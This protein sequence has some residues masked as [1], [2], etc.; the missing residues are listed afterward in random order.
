MK[1]LT[2][3]KQKSY[4]PSLARIESFAKRFSKA[5]DLRFLKAERTLLP[6]VHGYEAD[7][8]IS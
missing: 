5:K 8:F 6:A 2:T 1:S 4:L 3:F 7:N